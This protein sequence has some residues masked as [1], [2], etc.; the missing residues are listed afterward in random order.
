MKWKEDEKNL[1]GKQITYRRPKEI[2]YHHYGSIFYH[3]YEFGWF[4]SHLLL[5]DNWAAAILWATNSWVISKWRICTQGSI[6]MNLIE[7]LWLG[8]MQSNINLPIAPLSR[9]QL[10]ILVLR[11]L[12]TINMARRVSDLLHQGQSELNI[13]NVT[14]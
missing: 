11:N 9:V 14:L 13:L 2:H 12:E 8:K 10:S 3:I 7:I 1:R 6:I 5:R 4:L